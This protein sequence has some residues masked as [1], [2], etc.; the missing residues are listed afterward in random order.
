M[1]FGVMTS[2]DNV[3]D[4]LSGRRLSPDPPPRPAPPAA[5]VPTLAPEAAR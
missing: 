5:A 1:R 4:A 2:T 3:P